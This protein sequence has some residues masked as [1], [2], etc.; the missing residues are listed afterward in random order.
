MHPSVDATTGGRDRAFPKDRPLHF[1][2]VECNA[3]H[4]S[5]EDQRHDDYKLLYEG[6]IC[7]SGV[8]AFTKSEKCPPEPLELLTWTPKIRTRVRLISHCKLRRSSVEPQVQT[9]SG[10]APLCYKIR[11]IQVKTR[12]KLW[13]EVIEWVCEQLHPLWFVLAC[14]PFKHHMGA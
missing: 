7:R 11:T 2:S 13:Y 1:S 5:I 9:T 4:R 8:P 3:M 12:Q 10:G 14:R 6:R